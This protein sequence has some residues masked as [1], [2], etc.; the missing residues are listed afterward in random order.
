MASSGDRR[1]G[2]TGKRNA[3]KEVVRDTPIQ[4]RVTRE[5]KHRYVRAAQA[6]GK[7][8]SAWLVDL[9]DAHSGDDK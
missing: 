4:I 3:K 7:T 8:M 2:N 6:V 9:A 5:Q 1:H